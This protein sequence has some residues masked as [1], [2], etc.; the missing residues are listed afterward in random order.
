MAA[1]VTK[2]A[3]VRFGSLQVAL[4]PDVNAMDCGTCGESLYVA[5]VEGKPCEACVNNKRIYFCKGCCL[6]F[7]WPQY[8][9]DSGPHYCR[10]EHRRDDGTFPVTLR[11]TWQSQLSAESSYTSQMEMPIWN[12]TPLEVAHAFLSS[13]RL[14]DFLHISNT[15]F[16]KWND[17]VAQ[18]IGPLAPV[19]VAAKSFVV[20]QYV[21]RTPGVLILDVMRYLCDEAMLYRRD[22]HAAYMMENIPLA[23][24]RSTFTIDKLLNPD[25]RLTDLMKPEDFVLFVLA[26]DNERALCFDQAAHHIW[27]STTAMRNYDARQTIIHI[28]HNQVADFTYDE[29]PPPTAAVVVV[30]APS[31]PQSYS[32]KA[33]MSHQKRPKPQ[34][35]RQR[36]E[37]A[38]PRKVYTEVNNWC[39]DQGAGRRKRGGT[40]DNP[41]YRPSTRDYQ[42]I[43]VVNNFNFIVQVRGGATARARIFAEYPHVPKMYF[44]AHRAERTLMLVTCSSEAEREER[45]A[46]HERAM[47][48]DRIMPRNTGAHLKQL[49][50]EWLHGDV[51]RDVG[52]DDVDD[53]EEEEEVE[54]VEQLQQEDEEEEYEEE[55]EE[56]EEEELPKL[57]KTKV[58]TTDPEVEPPPPMDM[59][60]FD[61]DVVVVQPAP[62]DEEESLDY[63]LLF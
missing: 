1:Q 28:I 42:C 2:P 52:R 37:P 55:E 8:S 63:D 13:T 25:T 22:H 14:H 50:R 58:T 16:S 43:K 30:A 17:A 23:E 33:P 31:P 10:P 47:R 5:D 21:E 34:Q 6:P 38:K 39:R 45:I 9:P 53:E 7:L 54:E 41:C 32:Q 3:Y 26:D 15:T 12:C 60:K 19:L 46:N 18:R 11:M 49:L 29:P 61:D 48:S 56:G 36:S 57:K 62:M 59:P 27:A 20:Q 51:Y 4:A 24:T 35:K 40:A 44:G